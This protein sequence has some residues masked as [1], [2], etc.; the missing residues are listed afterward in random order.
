[1]NNILYKFLNNYF[2][3]TLLKKLRKNKGLTITNVSEKSK[4]PFTTLKRYEEGNTK[5]IPQKN[6]ELLT[7]FYEK[8][9]DYFAPINRLPLFNTVHGKFLFDLYGLKIS[10]RDFTEEYKLFKEKEYIKFKEISER[11]LEIQDLPLEE[12]EEIG[13]FL[14]VVYLLSKIKKV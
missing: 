9:V 6:I 13:K 7:K 1:M 3:Y 12:K 14:I 11:L 8:P 5:N 4:I 10:E 2:D